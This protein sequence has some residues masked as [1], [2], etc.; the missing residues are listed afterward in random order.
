MIIQ[1]L[2]VSVA[3]C[4]QENFYLR[5]VKILNEM[6]TS[7]IGEDPG[8]VSGSFSSQPIK[9]FMSLEGKVFSAREHLSNQACQIVRDCRF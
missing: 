6:E 7:L 9:Y 5:S 3:D 2:R 4:Q 8:S 1:N